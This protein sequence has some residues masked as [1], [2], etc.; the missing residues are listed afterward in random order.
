MMRASGKIALLG[1]LSVVGCQHASAR[2]V[3]SQQTLLPPADVARD[4]VQ[5]GFEA[6]CAEV[7]LDPHASNTFYVGDIARTER[8]PILVYSSHY[9]NSGHR[10]PDL[11]IYEDGTATSESADG[12]ITI[13]HVVDS[14]KFVARC[15][16]QKIDG[17]DSYSSPRVRDG[18]IESIAV[19]VG[20]VWRRVTFSSP[21]HD[22]PTGERILEAKAKLIETRMTDYEPFS[23]PLKRVEV[24]EVNASTN[25]MAWPENLPPLPSA[26]QWTAPPWVKQAAFW[27]DRNHGNDVASFIHDHP[28]AELVAPNGMHVALLRVSD[29]PPDAPFLERVDKCVR[30][31]AENSDC[32]LPPTEDANTF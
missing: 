4:D 31:Q 1:L 23:G 25:A 32:A 12:D 5:A 7:P 10:R 8:K 26:V 22:H 29:A 6:D 17:I 18:K 21:D 15:I 14:P 19:R 28:Y 2:S 3:A 11:V 9:P 20:N 30:N 16:A 24:Q 13:A 27:I